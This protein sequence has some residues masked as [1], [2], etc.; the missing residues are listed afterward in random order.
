MTGF[1]EAGRAPLMTRRAK[2]TESPLVTVED[3]ARFAGSG[4]DPPWCG[5]AVV[6]PTRGLPNKN[7]TYDANV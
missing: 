6:P 3:P 5:A 2:S 4:A 1:A 7:K